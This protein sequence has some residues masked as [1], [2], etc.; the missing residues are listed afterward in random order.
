[1]SQNIYDREAFFAGYSQLKRSRE[2]LAGAPEW[3]SL[4]ALLPPLPGARVLDLGCGFG[5][6]SRFAREQGAASVLGLEISENMLGRARAMT[7]DAAIEYRRADLETA[8]LPEAEFDLAFSSLTLHYIADLEGLLARI[9]RSL[10]PGGMLV[11]SMEHPIFM[12]PSR[13]E[14]QAEDGRHVWPLDG[15]FHEGARI[16][17]WFVPGVVMRHRTMGTLLNLIIGAGLTLTHVEDWRP[18]VA[19]IAEVP[20]WRKELERPMFLLLAARKS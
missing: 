20:E 6:F 8:E 11:L 10:V 1:M 16:K 12:A 5:W 14:W 17:E 15:Y 18:T 7:Q 9:Q 3:P 13:P 2:G 19:Q 4:R